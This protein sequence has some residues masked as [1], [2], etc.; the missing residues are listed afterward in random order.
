MK[1]LVCLGLA[2]GLIAVAS[3]LTCNICSFRVF[4]ICLTSSST[5]ACTGSCA[6]TRA[7]LGSVSLFS[8]QACQPNCT[9]AS[10]AENTFG[11]N[12]TTSCCTTDQCNS[13]NSMKISSSLGLGMVLLWLLNAL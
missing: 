13:G 11:F 9:S 10:S 2:L 12:Y 3:A 5:A 1:T 7:T 8:K 4:S 6:S